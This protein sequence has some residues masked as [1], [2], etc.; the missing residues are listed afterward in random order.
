MVAVLL[1]MFVKILSIQKK[2]YYYVNIK[3]IIIRL[4]TSES[5]PLSAPG[6]VKETNS[7]QRLCTTKLH[8]EKRI[9]QISKIFKKYI[10]H[11]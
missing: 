4:L 1:I 6:H 5:G 8:T 11:I 7:W 10:F 9:Y 2:N 3:L